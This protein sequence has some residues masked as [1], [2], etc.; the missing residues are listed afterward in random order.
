MKYWFID[1][2]HRKRFISTFICDC[3]YKYKFAFEIREKVKSL[4]LACG[5]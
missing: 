5:A 1:T 4:D 3:L 2:F